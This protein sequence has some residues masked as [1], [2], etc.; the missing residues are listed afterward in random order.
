MF[1]GVSLSLIC[2][3]VLALAAV[4]C[5]SVARSQSSL[6]A[7]FSKI[8]GPDGTLSRDEYIKMAHPP[9]YKRLKHLLSERFTIMARLTSGNTA[10]FNDFKKCACEVGHRQ[11]PGGTADG[12]RGAPDI[13]WPDTDGY[14]LD[15]D[16]A[17]NMVEV[18]VLPPWEEGKEYEVYGTVVSAGTTAYP[19][20]ESTTLFDYDNGEFVVGDL[21]VSNA[22]ATLDSLNNSAKNKIIAWIRERDYDAGN[23]F[24]GEWSGFSTAATRVFSAHQ[25][26]EMPY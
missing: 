9:V 4:F 23:G 16:S 10:N 24:P 3:P 20:P 21:V 7:E 18:W 15:V 8:A 6:E 25:A 5:P 2:L 12:M 22:G 26:P 14:V 19:D 17:Y 13:Y 1:R 11:H